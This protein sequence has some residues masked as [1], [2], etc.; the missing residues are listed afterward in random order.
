MA[1]RSRCRLGRDKMMIGPRTSKK[2][3]EES[4]RA[5]WRGTEV[6]DVDGADDKG[7][8]Q[9]EAVSRARR[10]RTAGRTPGSRG[11]VGSWRHALALL[12]QL[13]PP[14]PP[15]CRSP[16]AR[17]STCVEPA[18]PFHRAGARPHVT[19][20]PQPG[21]QPTRAS[22]QPS[23]ATRSPSPGLARPPALARATCSLLPQLSCPHA[24]APL[25]AAPLSS[26]CP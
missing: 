11:P 14:P 7:R 19:R 3:H 6:G 21:P 2:H 20:S 15:W 4:A 26:L 9:K 10:P 17:S 25:K 1:A 24:G 5:G 12:P 8:G 16:P 13:G 22:L 23:S 18:L